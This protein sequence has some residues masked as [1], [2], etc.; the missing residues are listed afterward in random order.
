MQTKLFKVKDVN[1]NCPEMSNFLFKHHDVISIEER[2][3]IETS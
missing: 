3:D 2:I 1:F